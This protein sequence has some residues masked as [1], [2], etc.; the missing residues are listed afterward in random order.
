MAPRAQDCNPVTWAEYDGRASPSRSLNTGN[1]AEEN[2]FDDD[3]SEG[4]DNDETRRL[5][6]GIDRRRYD[7]RSGTASPPWPISAASTAFELLLAAGSARPILP[8]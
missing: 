2:V 1:L 7:P 4:G 5:F 3:D 8:K 6:H